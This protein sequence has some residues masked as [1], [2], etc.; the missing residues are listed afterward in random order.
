MII[1]V[2]SLV[3]SSPIFSTTWDSQDGQRFPPQKCS[4]ESIHAGKQEEQKGLYA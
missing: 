4:L 3:A 1:F 2:M